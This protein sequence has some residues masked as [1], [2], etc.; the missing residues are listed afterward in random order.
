MQNKLS[1]KEDS[2]QRASVPQRVG[3]PAILESVWDVYGEEQTKYIS[4]IPRCHL[5]KECSAEYNKQAKDHHS[6]T[7]P[8]GV[9]CV[10]AMFTTLNNLDTALHPQIGVCRVLSTISVLSGKKWTFKTLAN[11]R[12]ADERELKQRGF[13]PRSAARG[14]DDE[15]ATIEAK[16]KARIRTQSGY[17]TQK[18][19]NRKGLSIEAS[20]RK[21]PLVVL[22]GSERAVGAAL[23]LLG[24]L[25]VRRQSPPQRVLQIRR[26]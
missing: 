3:I 21:S 13:Q 12:Q 5:W 19:K 14:G 4:G 8:T 24:I 1:G 6:F 17:Q 15:K 7:C 18:V 16:R 23:R 9:S 11:S 20:R 22:D 26:S 25:G 2:R 10:S